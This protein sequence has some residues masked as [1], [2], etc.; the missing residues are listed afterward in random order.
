M[1]ANNADF[2]MLLKYNVS[3]REIAT[4]LAL[5]SL[6]SA[7]TALVA[8]RLFKINAGLIHVIAVAVQSAIFVG[9]ALSP[10]IWIAMALYAIRDAFGILADS[11]IEAFLI[12]SSKGE[13]TA[14]L[15]S[16]AIWEVSTGIG[17]LFGG[18]LAMISPDLPFL[19]ASA[20]FLAYAALFAVSRGLK[21]IE[22]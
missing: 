16:Q 9:M 14:I 17:K 21:N 1:S 11:T 20:I 12:E 22:G 4:M 7:S 5:A 13:F 10:A 6:I 15:L 8:L 19:L 18:Y 3:E 2:Y